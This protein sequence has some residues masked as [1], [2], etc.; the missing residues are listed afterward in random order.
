MER[1]ELDIH[2]NRQRKE[3]CILAI[4]CGNKILLETIQH[5][6]GYEILSVP[7]GPIDAASQRIAEI[8]GKEYVG[9]EKPFGSFTDLIIKPEGEVE[10]AGSV[11]RIEVPEGHE[12][13]I[14]EGFGWYTKE[15]IEADPRCKRDRRFYS[16]LLES[17]PLNLKYSESQLEKWIDAKILSWDE[18]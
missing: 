2:G 4:I 12:I 15:Q 18:T 16:R 7:G 3:V 5:A 11:L 8:L 14:P 10:L 13:T 6:E 9:A 17:R 1:S